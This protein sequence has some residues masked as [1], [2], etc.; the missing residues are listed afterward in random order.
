MS[1]GTMKLVDGKTETWEC[2][3]CGHKQVIHSEVGVFPLSGYS[4]PKGCKDKTERRFFESW[5]VRLINPVP[6]SR[7]LRKL[8]AG[9]VV[10]AEVFPHGCVYLFHPDCEIP[11]AFN[12]NA[13]E[14]VD[15][16]EMEAKS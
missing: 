4:C 16:E 7:R 12:V 9:T 1:T 8:D 10:K 15:F 13:V 6:K 3:V 5:D 11:T 2:R 14:G